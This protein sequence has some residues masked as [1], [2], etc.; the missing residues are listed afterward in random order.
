MNFVFIK[1]IK[2]NKKY[3]YFL[4]LQ[5]LAFVLFP[6]I[7]KFMESVFLQYKLNREEKKIILELPGLIEFLKSYLLSGLHLPLALK[8]LLIQKK[9]CF[10]ISS[11]LSTIC[12]H[13]SQG[14][15]FTE[16]LKFGISIAKEKK[17]RQFLFLLLTTIRQA[18]TSSENVTQILEKVKQKALDSIQLERKIKTTTAQMKLQSF[19]IILSPIFLALILLLIS[20]NNILFFVQTGVGKF[21]LFFMIVMNFLGAYFLNRILKIQ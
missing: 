9:W 19:V 6:W 18:C 2:I 10:P 4:S 7:L 3:D 16:S 13:Y 20:P 15:G 17:S 12:I 14:K 5:P 11:A 21:L 1:S 8:S